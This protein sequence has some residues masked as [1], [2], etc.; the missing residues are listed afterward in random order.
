MGEVHSIIELHGKQEALKRDL[1]RRQVE[2]AAAYMADE[3]AGIGYLSV[4][5]A[6]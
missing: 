5:G 2:A 3:E 4:D 1:D 6:K